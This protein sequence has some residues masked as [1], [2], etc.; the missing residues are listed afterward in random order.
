M[1]RVTASLVALLLV[2]GCARDVYQRLADDLEAHTQTFYRSLQAGQVAAAIVE[3]EQ[4][5]A[6]AAT[7]QEGILRRH[8]QLGANQID[9]D[10]MMVITAKQA[11]AENWLALARYLVQ[12]KQYER[13]RGTYERVLAS[14]R[15]EIDRVY[16]ERARTGLQDLK[17]ILAPP[18][19]P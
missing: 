8:H 10:W 15:D 1:I 12:T 18:T 3:N 6:T 13:A 4:I 2:S 7:L 5:E 14:D 19:T 11:A 17:M 9:R 16:A